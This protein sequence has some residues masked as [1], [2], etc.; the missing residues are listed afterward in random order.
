MLAFQQMNVLLVDPVSVDTLKQC[1]EDFAFRRVWTAKDSK[2]ALEVIKENILDLVVT[3]VRLKPMSGYQLLSY[4]RE[5]QRTEKVPVL[6]VVDRKDKTQEEQ[7]IKLGA[8]GFINLPLTS[9]SVQSTVRQMLETMVDPR[10][11]EY[12]Q[13]MAAARQAARKKDWP[14]AAEAFSS[15]LEIQEDTAARMGLAEAR[16]AEEDLPGAEVEYFA[17]IRADK[18]LLRAYLG[19]TGIYQRQDRPADACK[20]L[21]A[22]LAS[23]R[24]SNKPKPVIADI[25]FR[26]GE[27][28]LLVKNTQQALADFEEAC[29]ENPMDLEIP[30]KVGDALTEAGELDSSEA[31][32]KRALDQDPKLAH[33]YNRLGINY[34]KQ[35]KL[36]LAMNL[37][38]QALG[39]LPRDEHLLY[40]IARCYFDGGKRS[41]RSRCCERPWPSIRSSRRPRPFSP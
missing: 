30:V 35:N 12:L 36:D 19:L 38:R 2:E 9:K 3:G 22:A 26:L 16:L 33:V 1:L 39:H 40:N 18:D 13:H 14:K 27:L 17:A 4:I 32:Y 10:E 29:M 5:N 21:R 8:S 25:C 20:I 31:F 23:A 11:E 24:R 6:L 7:G 34:R 41:M 15:A 37:Y 28:S